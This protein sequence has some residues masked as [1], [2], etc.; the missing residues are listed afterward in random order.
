MPDIPLA[1][2]LNSLRTLEAYPDLTKQVQSIETHMSWV[3]LTDEY[4]YKL[5]KP[6]RYPYLDYS[7]LQRRAQMCRQEVLLNRRLAEWV[8]LDTIPLRRDAHGNLSLSLSRTVP[9][10]EIVEWLVRMRRLPDHLMLDHCIRHDRVPVSA[11][12]RT[13]G[14]LT[15]FFQHA[16]IARI[17]PQEHLHRLAQA[18]TLNAGAL[19]DGALPTRPVQ[20]VIRKLEGF[21][22]HRASLFRQRAQGHRIV[23]GH[24]DLRPEHIYL[25]EPAAVI[26]CIEF[27]TRLR[28]LDPVEELAFLWMECLQSGAG[29]WGERFLNV[30]AER[31]RDDIDEHHVQFYMSL[32]ACLRARLALGHLPDTATPQHWLDKARIYFGLAHRFAAELAT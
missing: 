32:R 3:F 31:S 13:A 8:Y 14:H 2:K 7:T 22:N 10:G 6:V 16:R 19:L 4:A 28:Q 26:D 1:D 5:K 11:I 25:G 15:T 29:Q 24:G 21:L 12:D 30:Y 9:A 18:I 20:E 17:G 27:S 23:D